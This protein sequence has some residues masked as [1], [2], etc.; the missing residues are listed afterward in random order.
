VKLL[1]P[2]TGLSELFWP[3]L[4]TALLF[5]RSVAGGFCANDGAARS[6]AEVSKRRKVLFML[7]SSGSSRQHLLSQ[8]VP[9][10]PGRSKNM[11]RGGVPTAL[12]KY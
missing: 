2:E 5:G 10:F 9:S 12:E 3:E 4:L 11:K 1:A 7:F 8:H 6:E